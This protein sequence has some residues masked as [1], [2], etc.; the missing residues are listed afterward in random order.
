MWRGSVSVL[1]GGGDTGWL[2]ATGQYILEHGRLPQFD[3][4]TWTSTERP[5]ICY[6]WLFEVLC[7]LLYRGGGLLAVAA[8]ALSISAFLVLCALPLQWLRRGLPLAL[9]FALLAPA[10]TPF[11]FFARPQLVT[12]LAAFFFLAILERWR[13]APASKSIY[14]LPVIVLFWTNMHCFALLGPLLIGAYLLF[15]RRERSLLYVF[16]FS[17]LALFVTP[18]DVTTILQSL[19]IFVHTD[20]TSCNELQPLYLTRLLLDPANIY[21]FVAL[22]LLVI[23]HKNV[24]VVGL[25]IS[26]T[27]LLAGLA[28]ARLQPLGV[29][30]SWPFVGLSLASFYE[31][32]SVKSTGAGGQKNDVVWFVASLLFG[33]ILSISRYPDEA[34]ARRAYLGAAETLQFVAG[35]LKRDSHIFNDTISGSR[36]IFLQGPPVYIDSRLFLFDA[37]FYKKW[38]QVINAQNDD[39]TDLSAWRKFAASGDIDAVVLAHGLSFYQTLLGASDWLL[40]MDD[41]QSSFW[42]ADNPGNRAKL[43][44][45]AVDLERGTGLGLSGAALANDTVAKAAKHLAV[46]RTFFDQGDFDAAHREALSSLHMLRSAG[47]QAL[48]KRLECLIEGRP[49]K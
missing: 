35:H 40:V 26:L 45:W 44:A 43:K 41:G 38:L 37:A 24:P 7:A 10:L 36:L 14:F 9:S 19:N 16:A 28:V 4:F 27:A 21:V 31:A 20:P 17:F 25:V 15:C 13:A 42:L 29:I 22:T 23:K 39:R 46:A 49:R 6:Q 47:A 11:W 18:F 30:L 5:F 34:A 2:L 1:A 48:L 33:L 32:A 12:Y 8:V 3:I